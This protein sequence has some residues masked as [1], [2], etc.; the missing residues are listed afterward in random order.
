MVLEQY[1]TVSIADLK[2]A[3]LFTPHTREKALFEWM[4]GTDYASITAVTDGLGCVPFALLSYY[5]NGRPVEQ[6]VTLRWHK[7]HNGGGFYYFVCPLSGLSCE[8][9]YFSN[10]HGQFIGRVATRAQYLNTLKRR[11]REAITARPY[12]WRIMRQDARAV[13]LD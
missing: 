2:R 4:R 1:L 8:K 10:E 12:R 11:E 6:G 13:R 5:H 7:L 3:G 9:L